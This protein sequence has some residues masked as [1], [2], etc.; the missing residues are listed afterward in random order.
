MA[1]DQTIKRQ[2]IAREIMNNVDQMMSAL[3]AAR[4][5]VNEASSSGLTFVDEDFS[6]STDMKHI[7]AANLATAQ[8]NV[9]A[10]VTTLEGSSQDDVFNLIRP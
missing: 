4:D 6:S 3:Y 1:I 5:A 2:G 7:T 8:S 9:L 10:L